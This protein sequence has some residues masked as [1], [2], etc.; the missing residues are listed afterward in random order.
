MNNSQVNALFR[1][2]RNGNL[3]W[4]LL[5]LLPLGAAFAAEEE[6]PSMELLEFL[7]SWETKDGEWLDPV[8]MLSALLDEDK[9]QQAQSEGKQ[10]D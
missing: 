9:A 1:S 3:R 8:S 6:Q 2:R 4:L 7:G 10:N 5:A